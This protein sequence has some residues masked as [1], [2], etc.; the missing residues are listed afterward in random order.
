MSMGSD[1]LTLGL[2]ALRD[3]LAQSATHTT[4]NGLTTTSCSVIFRQQV[5]VVDDIDRA[6]IEVPTATVA[7]V[8]RDDYFLISGDTYRWSV[9]D[10][11]QIAD[12]NIVR[13]QRAIGRT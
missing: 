12:F 5:G 9:I 10:T 1:I 13:V 7:T 11:K 4:A 3:I 2:T 8:N 6:V